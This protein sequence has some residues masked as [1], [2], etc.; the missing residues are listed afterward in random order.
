MAIAHIV[1]ARIIPRRLSER[2]KCRLVS[3]SVCLCVRAFYEESAVG[4]I[5]LCL[6]DIIPYTTFS[7]EAQYVIINYN[8]TYLLKPESIEGIA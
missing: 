1:V 3:K 5:D 4:I 8:V 7:K 2:A 6:C